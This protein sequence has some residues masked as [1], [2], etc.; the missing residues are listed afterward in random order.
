MESIG[1]LFNSTL[2]TE[3]D[4]NVYHW[5]NFIHSTLFQEVLARF[6]SHPDFGN[7]IYQLCSKG[8]VRANYKWV[9]AYIALLKKCLIYITVYMLHLLKWISYIMICICIYYWPM[10]ILPT[11]L[12]KYI[13]FVSILTHL[14]LHRCMAVCIHS[15]FTVS[16]LETLEWNHAVPSIS[17]TVENSKAPKSQTLHDYMYLYR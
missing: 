12:K 13:K 5:R 16:D 1:L 9:I 2:A 3:F 15:R 10:L 4:T 17:V 14:A 7:Q 8:A 11:F 6:L